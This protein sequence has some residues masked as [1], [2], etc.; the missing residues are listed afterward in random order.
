V[1]EEIT[2]WECQPLCLVGVG[3]VESAWLRLGY[4][5]LPIPRRYLGVTG[6]GSHR[7]LKRR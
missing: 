4:W 1:Q 6:E 7:S 5:H 2:C 3:C